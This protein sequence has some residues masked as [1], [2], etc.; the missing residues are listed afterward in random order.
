MSDGGIDS[1][2]ADLS[3][4]FAAVGAEAPTMRVRGLAMHSDRVVPQGLF[5]ACAGARHGLEFLPQALKRGAAAVA[6]EPADGVSEP[7]LPD[8]VATFS[9]PA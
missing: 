7:S 6:W 2:G 3:R 9:V 5:L 4:L 8:G 1:G